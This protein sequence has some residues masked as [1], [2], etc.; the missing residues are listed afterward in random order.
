MNAIYLLLMMSMIGFSLFGLFS[1]SRM[2]YF[3]DFRLCFWWQPHILDS[4]LSVHFS[5]SCLFILK[6]VALNSCSKTWCTQVGL[7][8][9]S[10]NCKFRLGCFFGSDGPDFSSHLKA[11]KPG[12]LASLS[13]LREEGSQSQHAICKPSPNFHF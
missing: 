7:V 3:S 8:D 13:F 10:L 11:I 5:L 9:Y 2:C 6:S 12:Y 4:S 1:S